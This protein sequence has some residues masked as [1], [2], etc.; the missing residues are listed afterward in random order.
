M[1]SLKNTTPLLGGRFYHLYNRGNNQENIFFEKRNYEYFLSLW[2]R[3][4]V[5]NIEILAYCLLPNHFHLLIKIP[6][7]IKV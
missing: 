1:P 4:L 5:A 6:E 3:Y 2:N 7:N